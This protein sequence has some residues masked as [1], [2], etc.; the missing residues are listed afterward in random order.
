MSTYTILAGTLDDRTPRNYDFHCTEPLPVDFVAWRHPLQMLLSVHCLNSV[1]VPPG[2]IEISEGDN[3]GTA[4]KKI[5]EA[6]PPE[7]GQGNEEEE[8]EGKYERGELYVREVGRRCII[9]AD[10]AFSRSRTCRH[11]PRSRLY[12]AVIGSFGLLLSG[13]TPT[14]H[15]K[16]L[17]LTVAS[18]THGSGLAHTHS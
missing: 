7:R 1:H 13:V 2:M 9:V 4:A 8:K 15:S 11:L 5:L 3:Y 12:L 6:L 16:F 17:V 14:V 10:D 18:G